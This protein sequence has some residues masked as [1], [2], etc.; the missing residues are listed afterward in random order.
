M[1]LVPSAVNQIRASI[2]PSQKLIEYR[3]YLRK[4]GEYIG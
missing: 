3:K 1:I 4:V 2:Q